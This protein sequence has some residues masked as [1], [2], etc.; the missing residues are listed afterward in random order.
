M[1]VFLGDFD[2]DLIT[3]DDCCLLVCCFVLVFLFVCFL[4]SFFLL[5]F[6]LRGWGGRWGG[7]G[8]AFTDK[9]HIQAISI[10]SLVIK[11]MV[12]FVTTLLVMIMKFKV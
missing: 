2:D 6:F 12:N 11:W 7:G 8:E 3:P 10:P 1:G 5:F 9:E 4:L